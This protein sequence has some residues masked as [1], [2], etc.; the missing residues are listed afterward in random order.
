MYRYEDGDVEDV[1]YEELLKIL[2]KDKEPSRKKPEKK[3]PVVEPVVEKAKPARALSPEL[4][5][6]H[7]VAPPVTVDEGRSRAL[8]TDAVFPLEKVDKEL[9]GGVEEQNVNSEPVRRETTDG[10]LGKASNK[11]SS[12][13]KWKLASASTLSNKLNSHNQSRNTSPRIATSIPRANSGIAARWLSAAKNSDSE[14]ERVVLTDTDKG[15]SSADERRR[16]VSKKMEIPTEK[17]QEAK[18]SP[19]RPS[20][21]DRDLEPLSP[22]RQERRSSLKEPNSPKLGP[23]RKLSWRLNKESDSEAAKG[24]N[25]S[26][27]LS[28]KQR[29]ERKE[30]AKKDDPSSPLSPTEPKR[31]PRSPK[32]NRWDVDALKK[33][34]KD[35]ELKVAE[36]SIK[37]RNVILKATIGK[38]NHFFFA[39]Y[40]LVITV[41]VCILLCMCAGRLR[42]Y[43]CAAAFRQWCRLAMSSLMSS[44][45]QLASQ[46]HVSRSEGAGAVDEELLLAQE[47][48]QKYESQMAQLRERLAEVLMCI[49]YP[50]LPCI[51]S[52]TMP[53]FS[54][55]FLH[56]G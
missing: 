24:T 19:K 13:P 45:K 43:K 55:C 56:I 50:L 31:S 6:F 3:E 36:M 30:E 51:V 5:S 26:R 54:T 27:D 11:V 22:I 9:P 49:F 37:H 20:Q 42:K 10:V 32:L 1:D 39:L 12:Q 38:H 23:K 2:V 34:A 35:A 46:G 47:H 29:R 25:Q 17:T 52:Q 41:S 48:I 53:L 40:L 4:V 18:L 15:L 16:P 21:K 28:P 7:K 14:A 8:T 44:V 33:Q